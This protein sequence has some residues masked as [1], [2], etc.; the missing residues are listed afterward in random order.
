MG[1][2]YSSSPP[3]SISPEFW[4]VV[5]ALERWANPVSIF[6]FSSEI[7]PEVRS[8]P[9]VDGW[10]VGGA[11][12]GVTFPL[13]L[14]DPPPRR[15]LKDV[16]KEGADIFRLD[17]FC[18]NKKKESWQII[19][20]MSLF[21][22]CCNEV[23]ENINMFRVLRETR[24]QEAKKTATKPRVTVSIWYVHWIRNCLPLNFEDSRKLKEG[25]RTRHDQSILLIIIIII[26]RWRSHR[27]S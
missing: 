27:H 5:L 14:F 9:P 20:L 19:Y 13:L 22:V 2:E 12:G 10:G 6:N 25:S 17:S 4:W 1:G 21:M 26:L 23:K 24:V 3:K 16:A 18:K 11:G 8:S 7:P 15:F